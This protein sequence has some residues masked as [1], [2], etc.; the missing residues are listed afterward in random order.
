MRVDGLIV[1]TLV[2]IFLAIV[3][4]NFISGVFTII[5]LLV[6]VLLGL[7]PMGRRR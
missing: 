6:A 7:S 5:F 3:F 2:V 1:G 4:P